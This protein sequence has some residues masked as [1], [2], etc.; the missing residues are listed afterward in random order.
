[1]LDRHGWQFVCKL[2][3]KSNNGALRYDVSRHGTFEYV[4]RVVG[5]ADTKGS[6]YTPSRERRGRWGGG[7]TIGVCDEKSEG[8]LVR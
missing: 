1:M 8:K 2:H 3:R 5:V 4:N 7:K 6:R